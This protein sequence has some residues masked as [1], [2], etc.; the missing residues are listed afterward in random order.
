MIVVKDLEMFD[1]LIEETPP[2]TFSDC[3][4]EEEYKLGERSKIFVGPSL[5]FLLH[6]SLKVLSRGGQERKRLFAS[7]DSAS[8]NGSHVYICQSNPLNIVISEKKRIIIILLFFRDRKAV[9]S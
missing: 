6:T 3:G 9:F 8:E 7:L 1:E 2:C 5:Y 4:V